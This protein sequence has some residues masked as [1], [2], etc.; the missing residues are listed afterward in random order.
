MSRSTP[1]SNSN[2]CPADFV[3]NYSI[4]TPLSQLKRCHQE[5][6]SHGVNQDEQQKS[7]VKEKDPP[8]SQS[9]KTQMSKSKQLHNKQEQWKPKFNCKTFDI[10]EEIFYF[11]PNKIWIDGKIISKISPLVYLVCLKSTS[12]QLKAHVDHLKRKFKNKYV[13]T[14]V[15][16]SQSIHVPSAQINNP[17]VNIPG[18]S[19]QNNDT[20]NNSNQ[21]I[22]RPRTRKIN[23]KV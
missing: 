18:T 3:L 8:R 14:Y 22:L 15:Q 16:S 4:R 23:Y 10:D 1:L 7:Q 17:S 13:P 6:S 12:H 21:R 11:S 2:E 19:S 9:N 5:H 20:T